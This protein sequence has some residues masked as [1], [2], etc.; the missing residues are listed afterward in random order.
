[1][2]NYE[3]KYKKAIEL[4]KQAIEHAIQAIESIPG[5][6]ESEVTN[7]IQQNN[8]RQ[9]VILTYN[10]ES[11][12]AAEWSDMLH[13]PSWIILNRKKLGWS[14]EDTLT[15]PLQKRTNRKYQYN[16]ELQEKLKE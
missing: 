9:N 1:M 8:T 14:D 7:K 3:E 16:N 2:G 5:L 12:T 6:R 11:H 13:L 15:R 4:A 10:G